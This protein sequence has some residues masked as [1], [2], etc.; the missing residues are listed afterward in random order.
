[1]MMMMMMTVMV[2]PLRQTHDDQQQ[3]ANNLFVDG[4][5]MTAT[6]SSPSLSISSKADHRRR[7]QHHRHNSASFL[8]ATGQ[9]IGIPSI[10]NKDDGLSA[11]DKAAAAAGSTRRQWMKQTVK[12]GVNG[13][14]LGILAVTTAATPASAAVDV[15]AIQMKEFVDPQGLFSLRVPS[16][17][18]TLR[19]SAKGDLPDAKTGKGR[20]G[21]SIFTAGNMAK[22]EVV[23]VERFPVRVLLEEN[24]IILNDDEN[25]S[26]SSSKLST[27]PSIGEARTIANLLVVRRERETQNQNIKS[28]ENV[29]LS[30]DGKELTFRLKTEIEVQKPELLLEQYGI[31][32]LF[33]ITVA[34]ATLNS[35]DGNLMA[36]FASAL[37]QDFDNGV[38]GPALEDVVQSFQVTDQS[39]SLSVSS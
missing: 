25:S 34:K 1:M 17:F 22:A 19:R 28:I 35:N 12:A 15:S 23:A 18:Y 16:S 14:G 10:D 4:W 8:A 36:I 39:S 33:R 27:F 21:S 26:S 31:S 7:H 2:E 24:G 5:T 20:R 6:S 3:L 37:E 38:D 32:Q 29:Q 13:M 30:P 9:N 11:S